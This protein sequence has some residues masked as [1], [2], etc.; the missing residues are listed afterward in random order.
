[1]SNAV[2]DKWNMLATEKDGRE[3]NRQ[4]TGFHIKAA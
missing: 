2:K 4:I 1:M 3:R